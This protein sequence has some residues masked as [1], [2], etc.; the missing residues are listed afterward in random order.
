[1]LRLLSSNVSSIIIVVVAFFSVWKFF[2]FPLYF[3]HH[4][5]ETVDRLYVGIKSVD[6]D[7]ILV[8]TTASNIPMVE[9]AKH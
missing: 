9:I 8:P 2:F 1:M 4:C 3:G 5:D 7:S 6:V